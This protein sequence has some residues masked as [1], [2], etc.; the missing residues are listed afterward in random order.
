[1]DSAKP[2]PPFKPAPPATHPH[3]GLPVSDYKPQ[4][5]EQ[6]DLANGFKADEE[7]LLRKLDGLRGGA[8]DIDPRW[9]ALARTQFEQAFMCLNRAVFQPGRASLPEDNIG[10]G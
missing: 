7:R 4:S 2:R 10:E 3:S 6:V 5:Q 8:Q 9:P 1:M